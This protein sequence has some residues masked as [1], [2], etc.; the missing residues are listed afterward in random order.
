MLPGIIFQSV[1]IGG[2]YATGREIVEYG[3]KFGPAG[4]WSIAVIGMG[5]SLIAILAF[6]YARVYRLYDYRSFV[7]SLIGPL[8]PM[9]DV[10]FIIMV[11][12]VI[13]VVSAASGRVVE[14]VLGLN[15]WS[16]V[17]FMMMLVGGLMA[18]GRAAIERF[19]TAGS[20]LLY[21]GFVSFAGLVIT[22]TWEHIT[23]V[24]TTQNT[25]FSGDVSIPYLMFTGF[26]YVG[27]N[28]AALPSTF[29]S[30]D[31]QTERR[32][33]IWAGLITGIL[34]T[35]PFVLTYVAIMGY[36]PDSVVLDAPVPWLVML[37]E[38]GGQGLI[39][40]YAIVIFWTLVE[41]STGLIHAV[42][43][44]IDAHLIERGI[45]V[46]TPIRVGFF[47]ITLLGLAALL[48]RIGLI[49]LVAR[50]YSLLAYG[51]LL[52]LAL[53]LLTLGVARILG[54]K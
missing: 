50:G 34:A 51:F 11:I 29:F 38:V 7:R 32:H 49:T 5:F 36:Y 24:F 41:T 37:R 42:I 27:Y 10:V 48:S 45:P 15:Y 13:A 9:F 6:E 47:A 22:H 21:A 44:R 18:S 35:V 3:G 8:W 43:T 53:P 31:V 14:D 52:L 39:V 30:L 4:I 19:K 33:A 12:V 46:L 1:L 40:F 23:D 28:L 26:L 16:G 20:V 17:V 54:G 2:A 25:R